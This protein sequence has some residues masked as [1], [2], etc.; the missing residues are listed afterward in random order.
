[1]NQ[2]CM[3]F[4]AEKLFDYV[5]VVLLLFLVGREGSRQGNDSL[6]VVN[7]YSKRV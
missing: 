3:Y 1:M 6:S 4:F 5:I 2:C 7:P